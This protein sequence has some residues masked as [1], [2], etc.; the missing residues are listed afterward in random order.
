MKKTPYEKLIRA[1][2]EIFAP[3][4]VTLEPTE[5][6]GITLDGWLVIYVESTKL[7]R[8]CIGGERE[9]DGHLFHVVL[10]ERDPGVHRHSDGSG[11]PP[12]V[13]ENLIE[14]FEIMGRALN[15]A[16]SQ[17]MAHRI[18]CVLEGIAEAEMVEEQFPHDQMLG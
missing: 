2:N 14:S 13:D 12:S 8:K 10:M 18:G 11:T 15:L 1:C 7:K 4:G 5:E 6:N 3:L 16:A 9:Y 17:L